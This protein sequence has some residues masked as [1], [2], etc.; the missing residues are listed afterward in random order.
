MVVTRRVERRA[1]VRGGIA[2]AGSLAL[3]FLFAR[4]ARSEPLGPLVPDPDGLLD[5]PEGFSYRIL[6]E[7]GQTMSDGYR[8]P[9][10][11]DG[12][13]CF[14]GPNGTLVLL[15][16]HELSTSSRGPYP[17]G[18][19]PPPE[20]YSSADGGVT[21]LVVDRTTLARVSSNLVL[22]GT[23]RNCAGGP[24]PW[25]WLSCEETFEPEHGY[26]F[27][28][29]IDATSV[30]APERVVGYGR[31]RHEA[32]AIDPSGNVA[33]LTEDRPDSALYRFVPDDPA[34]PF[35]GTL[36][37]LRV[38][39]QNGFST[40]TGLT[41]GQAL[42]L[43]WVDLADPDPPSDTLRA[44]ARAAGAAVISRGE[45][46]WFDRGVVYFTS[47]DGGPV[48]SG[49][50][51]ALRPTATGGTLTLVAQSEDPSVLDGPDNICM[52]PWGDLF[53]AED[54]F[55]GNDFHLRGLTPSGEIHDFARTTLGELAGVCFSPDGRALFVNLF[56]A[57][58]TVVV[59]GPFP[60]I[61]PGGGSGGAA[62]E[63]GDPGGAGGS[64]AGETSGGAGGDGE[65]GSGASGGGNATG[66][67][68]NQS[69]GAGGRG[70]TGGPGRTVAPRAS[71]VNDD[72]G[73]GCDVPGKRSRR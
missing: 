18:V 32:V 31:F 6:D 41:V 73:C 70:T 27:V 44:T 23:V 24:S 67:R 36:Q 68:S 61:D 58:T 59:T 7:G 1:F 26:T 21:R 66:G 9:G 39:G 56:G 42:D 65:G 72:P 35:T 53:I 54:G 63:S 19:L 51:F 34:V 16:N 3:P 55:T 47:T 57:D 28:C 2:A 14:S 50:V 15:R 20:A 17:T 12:M 8:V 5:L 13:A 38:R 60:P 48:G 25:G 11:P 30:R 62:G 64:Q 10:N 33:Y 43:D 29:P 22:V 40:A 71:G 45:G 69:G 52:A 37:A 46:I 4:R 49:Q